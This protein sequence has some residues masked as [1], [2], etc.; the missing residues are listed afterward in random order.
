MLGE[1]FLEFLKFKPEIDRINYVEP[2]KKMLRG[3][4]VKVKN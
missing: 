2:F 4:L 1:G 3:E